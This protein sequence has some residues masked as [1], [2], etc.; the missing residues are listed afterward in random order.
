MNAISTLFFSVRPKEELAEQK[1]DHPQTSKL[2]S[3]QKCSASFH[4][5]FFLNGPKAQGWHRPQN[6]RQADVIPLE[7]KECCQLM[8]W[9]DAEKTSRDKHIV[10]N[11]LEKRASFPTIIQSSRL[12]QVDIISIISLQWCGFLNMIY[13]SLMTINL[14]SIVHAHN[15]WT[16][17]KH[18]TLQIDINH[19]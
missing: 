6:H 3:S 17:K 12:N 4:M 7:S 8:H 18:V 5:Y 16:H 1:R 13:V 10:K 15:P 2:N 11:T 14:I 9:V 19:N